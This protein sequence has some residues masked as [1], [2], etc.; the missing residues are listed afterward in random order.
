MRDTRK[1][2]VGIIGFGNFGRLAASILKDDFRVKVCHYRKREEDIKLA[3]KI[4]VELTT[5][6]NTLN[7]DVIVLA[8]PISKTEAAIKQISSKLKPGTLVLDTCSVK[9]YPC[10]WLKKYIPENVEIIGTHPM[11]G[12]TTSKFNFEKQ[13]WILEGLQIV[14]CP[15]RIKK[16]RQ[17]EVIKYLSKLGLKVIIT[18]P[19]DHDRQ[20]A[21]TLALVHYIG[22]SLLGAGIG[23]QEIYTKGYLDLLSILPHTTSDN[24]QLFYD[25]NNYNPYARKIIKK[26]QAASLKMEDRLIKADKE[27]DIKKNRD[28]ISEIDKQIARLLTKRFEQVKKIGQYKKKNN[29]RTKDSKRETQVINNALK[30]K[31][32]DKKFVQDLYKVIFN[33]SYKLQE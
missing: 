23:E 1:I 21:K 3:K 32:L 17:E 2:T 8:V 10:R 16:A 26:F 12:P 22:R 20:N 6:N 14:L 25:M 29:I 18:T 15:L 33:Q 13:K 31:K 28:I 7:S 19:E 4:N 9:T 5:L 24:W 11:F 30:E 27:S